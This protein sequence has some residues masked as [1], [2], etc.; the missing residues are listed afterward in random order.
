MNLAKKGFEPVEGGHHEYRSRDGRRILKVLLRPRSL[1]DLHAGF[2]HV[3]REVSESSRIG[4]GIVVAWM[5]KP[6]S[7]RMAKE[8][9]VAM[10]LFKPGIARRMALVVARPD[11]C[12]A[13]P[14]EAELRKVGEAVQADLGKVEAPVQEARPALSRMFFE[15]FKVLFR[16]WL[17]T[18]P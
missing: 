18:L 15:V 12:V 10:D 17:P 14:D 4:R 11:R 9:K 5:A 7:K 3:A 13:I 16:R 6:S 2:F 8:W 1:R